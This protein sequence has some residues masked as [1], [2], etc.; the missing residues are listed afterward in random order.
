MEQNMENVVDITPSPRVLRMLGQIDFK[1]WQCLAELIDNSIDSF[2]TLRD[3]GIPVLSP[4]ITIELPSDAEL[5]NGNGVLVIKDNGSGMTIENLQNAVRAGYSGNDPVEKMGLFGMGFNISTARL[6]RRT[7]VW[8]TTADSTQWIGIVIDFDQLERKKSFQTPLLFREKNEID[9][10]EKIHGTEVHV[11]KLEPS[12]IRP[13]MWGAGK[14]QTRNKLGKIYGRVMTALGIR[15]IYSGDLLKP[16]RHCVW[17]KTRSVPTKN[18]GFVPAYTEVNVSLGTRKYCTTCWV[19]LEQNESSC[20]SC[21]SSSKLI[22]RQRC[23]RGWIGIQRYF[24]KDHYGFDLIRNGRVIEELDK[25]LFYFE[26]GQSE[27]EL[28][29]P[30]DAI[31]WGGRIVGEL[32][33]DFVRV[34]HQKDSFDKLDPEWK[35]VVEIIRGN[36]PLR[37]QIAERMGMAINTSPLA[38]IYAGYRTGYAGLGAL[39]PG[40]E[41]G[42]GINS[43]I[44]R[45]YV[46]RFYAGEE[47]FQ[48]DEKWY[49]LVL[50]AERAKHGGTSADQEAGG[51]PPINVDGTPGESQTPSPD[52]LPIPPT[53]IEIEIDNNLTRIYDL[54]FR[55]TQISINAKARKIKGST[56]TQPYQVRVAGVNFEFDYN[57]EDKIFEESLD[58]PLD[59]FLID[60]SHHFLTISGQTPTD[61]PVSIL[62]RMLREKYF[63]QTISKVE[64]LTDDANSLLTALRN[65][66]DEYLPSLAPIDIGLIPTQE[67][68]KIEMRAYQAHLVDHDSVLEIIGKGR[69]IKYIDNDFLIDLV[70]LFPDI[71]MD[72][73]FFTNPYEAINIDLKS[74]AVKM[75]LDGLMDVHWMSDEGRNTISKDM[76][77]RLRY[78]R[79]IA[80][81]QL[82]RSWRS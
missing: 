35:Q 56:L 43:G 58:L 46:T 62:Q 18:F 27:K 66:L 51:E 57:P 55:Q 28:E 54:Y 16:W 3:S 61:Y 47:A 10:E 45:E 14:N 59:F 65:H 36:S 23:L 64:N 76:A 39:V 72:G 69:F 67:I 2:I 9:I 63:P 6:G 32:E 7:E 80:S 29:Y 22:E 13:L 49:E 40:D 25:S 19:W 50:Q 48:S 81:L 82:L 41:N 5:Q 68:K 21:G 70:E 15:I 11:M 31:H 4:Q 34:S 8:T 1:P 79:A 12:R 17:D 53:T 20:P 37:P 73:K 71:V 30:I 60:L 44:V 78:S 42:N 33:I 52:T 75:I 26:N 38:R 77:W 24:D 74:N